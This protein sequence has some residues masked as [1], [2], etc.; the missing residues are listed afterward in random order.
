MLR[1]DL[2]GRAAGTDVTAVRR[3]ARARRA[4]RVTRPGV[5][6]KLRRAADD[7]AA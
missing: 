2:H 6:R 7:T 4:P 1:P 5:D 3:E